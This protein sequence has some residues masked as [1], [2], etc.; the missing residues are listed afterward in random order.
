MVEHFSH[1]RDSDQTRQNILDVA[2]KEFAKFGL[3]GARV[4]RIAKEMNT[5]K[6]MIYYYFKDK[7]GLY[8]A[9][10]ERI[11]PCLRAEE[12]DLSLSELDPIAA[13]ERII[14]FTIDYHEQHSDF[15]RIVMIEN[16]NNA[17]YLRQTGIDSTISYVILLTLGDII[18]R[19]C[20]SGIFKRDITPVDLHILYTSFSFYRISNASTVSSVLG[21]NTLNAVN[22]KRHRQMIKDSVRAYM[23][24]AA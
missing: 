16:I 2:L 9:V 21:L 13:L 10:L 11:Y 1:I 23:T 17:E 3:A 6:G 22:S 18:R 4:D 19:G 14:D 24:S 15:V 20:E 8:K 5:T 12:Q 7:E